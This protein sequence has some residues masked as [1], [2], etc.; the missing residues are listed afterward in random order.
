MAPAAAFAEVLDREVDRYVSEE[1]GAAGRYYP[2]IATRGV[3]WFEGA[4]PVFPIVRTRR[5][6]APPRRLSA[7]QHDALEQFNALG[8]ALPPDFT[9]AEL[10]SAFCALARRYHPDRH[11]DCP[12]RDLAQL[13][14]RFASL[15]A[16]YDVL[17]SVL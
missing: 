14:R 15:R 11:P 13:S 3:F 5:A 2:G 6:A 10:R 7:S 16:A 12:E 1:P 4:T 8:A 9:R 17:R